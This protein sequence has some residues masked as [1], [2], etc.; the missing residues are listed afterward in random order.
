MYDD[1]KKRNRKRDFSGSRLFARISRV[2]KPPRQ[3]PCVHER[4]NE[5]LS[6]EQRELGTQGGPESADMPFNALK[7]NK[8]EQMFDFCCTF[9]FFFAIIQFD[10]K[11]RNKCL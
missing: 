10:R 4:M 3:P 6:D 2:R 7:K 9:K 5:R 8:T 1:I 11:D